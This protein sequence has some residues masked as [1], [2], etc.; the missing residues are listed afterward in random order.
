MIIYKDKLGF[1]KQ[2]RSTGEKDFYFVRV[3]FRNKSI[4]VEG[5]ATIKSDVIILILGKLEFNIYI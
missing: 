4:Y 3:Q 1:K 5:T 2:I